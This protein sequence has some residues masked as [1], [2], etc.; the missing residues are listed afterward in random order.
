MNWSHCQSLGA[1]KNTLDD[2]YPSSHLALQINPFP[3][4]RLLSCPHHHHPPPPPFTTTTTTIS[5]DPGAVGESFAGLR[6]EAV[7]FSEEQALSHNE[8][9]LSLSN[10]HP[11]RERLP[12][13]LV[14]VD[15]AQAALSGQ[16]V[17]LQLHRR[18]AEHVVRLRTLLRADG[19]AGR[20]GSGQ[21]RS[22][23]AEHVVRLRTLLGAD[24]RAGR[25]GLGLGRA[26]RRR[27][28]QSGG[29]GSGQGRAGQ[30]RSG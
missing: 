4:P 1:L 20:G 21:G 10:V 13:V 7:P 17:Q 23:Q 14:Q 22:G 15:P 9:S 5:T 29:G 25:G 27:A 28:G 3:F 12:G 6:V 16:H 18:Q 8:R 19:R 2:Y 24:G 30:I 11:R 26:G